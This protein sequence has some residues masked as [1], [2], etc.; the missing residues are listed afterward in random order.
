ME[1]H[2]EDRCP[3]KGSQQQI[4]AVTIDGATIPFL[5]CGCAVPMLTAACGVVTAPDQM[6]VVQGML[7]RKAVQ[8]LRD[9]GCSCV[10]VSHDLIG[11]V[12]PSALKTVTPLTMEVRK[13]CLLRKFQ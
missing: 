10:V 9:S 6:Q 7:N 11:P 2:T 4:T 13:L 8:V 12:S 5:G 1:D 3:K